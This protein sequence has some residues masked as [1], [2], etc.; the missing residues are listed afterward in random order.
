MSNGESAAAPAGIFGAL[1]KHWK[2]LLLFGILSVV[3]GVIGLGMAVFVTIASLVFF[4]IILLADGVVQFVQSFQAARWKAKLW[5]ILISFLYVFGGIVVVR[6]PILASSILTLM[7]AGA[8]TAIGIMRII[9]AFQMKGSPGWFWILTGG[10]LALILGILIFA[11][12]PA[13]S[14]VVI[15]TFIS[16]ELIL[17]GWSAITVAFA[18]KQATG[19]APTSDVPQPEPE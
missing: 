9:M 4:G 14:L 17:N 2:W 5:H 18:A 16:I 3:L 1:A 10:V 11:K 13:S 19:P 15:G 7:L 8:I 6:N 12:W